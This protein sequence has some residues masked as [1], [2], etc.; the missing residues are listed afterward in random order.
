MVTIKDAGVA[1]AELAN[2]AITIGGTSTALGGT[3]T[4]LT[5]L[6]DLDLTAGSKT[7]FDTIGANTLTIGASNT[8]VAIAGDLSVAGTTTTVNSTTET[9]ADPIFNL[10]GPSAPGSDDNKDRGVSFRWHNGSAAKI[11][12]FGF[13]DSTGKMT[14]IPDA[15]ISSE[16]VSGTAGNIVATTFEGALSGNATTATALATARTIG[17]VSFDGSANINLPGVN[18]T[19]NQDTSGNATTATTATNAT[20]VTVADNEST[21]ENNLIP[22][23][24]DASAT[25][26]VGLESDGDFHY[27]PSTGTLTA[28]TFSGSF[29]GTVTDATNVTVSANNSTDETVYP[30]FVDGATG[31]QGIETDTG[32]TYNPSSGILTATQFTGAVS[33]NASTA[34]AL[35]TGRTIGMTGDVVWTSASFDGSGNVTAAATIQT[36]AVQ[37]AMV[38]E[39]VI[40]GRTE[41]GSGAI[42][43]DADFLLVWDATDSAFKKVKPDNLGVSGL[44]SGSANEIQ[45]NNSSAFAGASNVEIKNNSL[46]LKEQAAPSNVSGYGMLYAKTDNELY[47][48]DDGGNETKI[49]NAG[50]L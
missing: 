19:G 30:T 6:T 25:G 45:Y 21:N 12:F 8:T 29:S 26:N 11:G 4:A 23:I 34:T 44:A 40:S 35:A 10:G 36:N 1:N 20:H 14:F 16:I 39:D 17:G 5:A 3:I 43:T 2:S 33:G 47:F 38:H 48:K 32:L 27:N 7:I 46:A 13:D 15:T 37:A 41:L 42:A 49:T 28:T 50:S 18:A 31:A 24:E 22:F 9:I